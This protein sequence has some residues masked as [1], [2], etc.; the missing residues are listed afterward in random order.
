MGGGF[1]ASQALEGEMAQ[2][3]LWDRTLRPAEVSALAHCTKGMLGNV[4][5]WREQDLEVY[6]GATM[7][8]SEPCSPQHT[9]VKQ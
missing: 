3:N 8:P 4:V 5:P 1:D 6:G 9:S 2:L 7:G